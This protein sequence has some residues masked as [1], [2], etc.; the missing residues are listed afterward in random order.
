MPAVSRNLNAEE[1]KVFLRLRGTIQRKAR[2]NALRLEY[3]DMKQK[4]DLT[5]FSIPEHMRDVRAALSWPYQSCESVTQRISPLGFT[6]TTK[7][8]LMDDLEDAIIDSSIIQAERL[9]FDSMAARSVSFIFITPGDTSIGEPQV[10]TSVCSA[11]TATAERD[12]RTRRIT[13]ALEVVDKL[14]NLLY[15]P[16]KTLR[17][18]SLNHGKW[19]VTFE[20]VGIPGVVMC[21]PYTWRETVERPFGH[22]RITPAVMDITDRFFRSSIREEVQADLFSVPRM[23]M[24]N[25]NEASFYDEEGNRIS[26]LK[27]MMGAVWG[28]PGW[29]D[30]ET[31]TLIEPTLQQFA[32]ASMEPHQAMRRGLAMEF[33]GE[34]K[35]PIGQLGIVQDN[36]SSADAIRANEYALV[37]LIGKQ[38]ESLADAREDMARKVL[39]T[40]H[41]EWTPSMAQDLRRLRGQFADPGTPTKSAQADAGM[42]IITAVPDIV[43]SG[44][45]L[46][47]LGLSDGQIERVEA[48]RKKSAAASM[49]DKLLASPLAPAPAAEPVA[50]NQ[51]P[52]PPAT[53]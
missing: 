41:G 25:A 17:V 46:E 40:I 52:A 39:A 43:G 12:K 1:E 26:P 33:S 21:T 32:Q 15:L 36:P 51:P 6:N 27:A 23:A 8:K 24:T 48:H 2:K 38:L 20:Y 35:I 22:S 44:V 9:A 7:T 19:T 30:D 11:D 10:I 49:L 45:E 42:K 47:A 13:S 18:Q 4:V 16:G 14:D 28:I 34:T 3:H 53:E 29:R 50:P 31:G 37:G 5:G